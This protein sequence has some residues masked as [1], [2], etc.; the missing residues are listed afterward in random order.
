LQN[1]ITKHAL[2]AIGDVPSAYGADDAFEGIKEL[3]LSG[4]LLYLTPALQARTSRSELGQ[5]CC[6]NNLARSNDLQ[7]R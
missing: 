6:A 1:D 4:S 3:T 7:T 5:G 2:P